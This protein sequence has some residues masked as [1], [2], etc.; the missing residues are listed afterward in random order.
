MS[1]RDRRNDERE[2]DVV[3]WVARM[4]IA[5]NLNDDDTDS[6]FRSDWRTYGVEARARNL[7][8]K[9]PQPA[10]AWLASPS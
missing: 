1:L 3:L 4:L 10:G 2:F 9:Y 8:I 7:L 5:N 6:K